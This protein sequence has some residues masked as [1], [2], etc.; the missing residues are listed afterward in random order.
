M[1]PATNTP[2][3]V[4]FA[5]SPTGLTH[6]GSA[7]TALYNYLLANHTGGQFI[8]RIE[9]T[10]QKRFDPAAEEDL[11]QSL[12]W[13]GLQWDE[14]P[15]VGGE[16]GPYRQ[17][18]RKVIY[19]EYAEKLIEMGK[20]YYCFCTPEEL[21]AKRE[22]KMKKK[23]Q[24][25]YDGT[26]RDIPLEQ[27][28]ARVAAGESH[29]IRFR[30]PKEGSITVT[31]YL[32]GD[33]IVDNK[34]IDDYIIVKSDGLALYHLAAMVDDHL[35]KITHV[36]RGEEWL[37]TFP[38]HGH[39][40]QAFGWEQPKWVHLSVFLKPSGKGKMSKRDTQDMMKS[41]RSIFVK[42]MAD[43]GYL[44]EGVLNWTA[45]MGWSYDDSTE[46]F[47][48]QDLVE[49]FSIDKLNPSSAAIDFKKLDHFN[50]LHIRSLEADKLA[51][52]LLPYYAA[53]GLPENL[54]MVRKFIPLIDTR[55]TT[56]DDAP[57]LTDFF[58]QETVS[59]TENELIGKN[60]T[61]Q[62]SIRA[63]ESSLEVFTRIDSLKTEDL[64]QPMR[65]LAEELELKLGQLLAPIRGA[66]TGKTV[67]PPL[68]ESMEII[69]KEICLGRINKAIQILKG[70]N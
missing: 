38:L 69:G 26:C 12:Q 64:E 23:E 32:R 19:Q 52:R 3:R 67:S 54:E 58:F 15:D 31:D 62:D 10:D 36:F 39:I 9:D 22:E 21:A 53:A 34:N 63:L 40:Y 51:Q 7:R 49:K 44:P 28:Q 14:G 59:P 37:A 8:L 20:A 43:L 70:S 50:K 17:S 33:I 27:A 1:T 16:Y 48:L 18:E 29:V 66:V 2:A 65:A 56:L 42:D 57:T 46:F 30:I 11:K 24:P 6:L 55:I 41:G 13:L 35:M 4:R 25:F 60:M 5:P 45:L 68:F 47:T 61:A